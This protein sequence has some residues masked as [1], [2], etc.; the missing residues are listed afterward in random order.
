MTQGDSLPNW[1]EGK[2][3]P[4]IFLYELLRCRIFNQ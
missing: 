2:E 3:R 1:G 4:V